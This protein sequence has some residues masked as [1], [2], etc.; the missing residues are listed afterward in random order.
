MKEV[1]LQTGK[2]N[3]NLYN[4]KKNHGNK[5]KQLNKNRKENGEILQ[6]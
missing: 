5:Y 4:N 3:K 6:S 2:C 1:V